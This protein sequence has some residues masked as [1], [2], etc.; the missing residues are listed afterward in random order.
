MEQFIWLLVVVGFI[1]Y[2][3]LIAVL[4]KKFRRWQR[5]RAQL[6]FERDVEQEMRLG[7]AYKTAEKKAAEKILREYGQQP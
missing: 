5:R 7:M 6:Q 1:L 4:L 3:A 2:C